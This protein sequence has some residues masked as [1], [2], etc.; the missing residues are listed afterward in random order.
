[1]H[2]GFFIPLLIFSLAFSAT[3]HADESLPWER[4]TPFREGTIHYRITGAQ[5]GTEILYIKDYGR[6]RV[7]ESQSTMHVFGRTMTTKTRELTSP[8]WVL[9]YNLSDN[10]GEKNTNPARLYRQEYEQLGEGEKKIFATNAAQLGPSLFENAGSIVQSRSGS[11]LGFQCDRISFGGFSSSC[12]L[13]D[14]DIPLQSEV[15]VVGTINRLQAVRIDLFSPVPDALFE[16]PANIQVAVNEEVEAMLRQAIHQAV[17]TL[18]QPGGIEALQEQA[19]Q[20]L[21][22]QDADDAESAESTESQLP[23]SQNP[24]RKMQR[25]TIR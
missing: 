20:F 21:P 9:R 23:T 22:G 10:W 16:P 24:S 11:I 19:R 5:Q 14:T 8:E 13:H 12:L 18:K 25:R 17:Q 3:A 6:K 1:M 4:L 15:R 7:K 2:S